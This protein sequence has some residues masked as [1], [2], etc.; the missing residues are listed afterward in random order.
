MYVACI[1]FSIVCSEWA[2]EACMLIVKKLLRCCSNGLH[3]YF[4]QMFINHWMI[5]QKSLNGNITINQWQH[6]DSMHTSPFPLDQEYNRN[7]REWLENSKAICVC[8]NY[9]ECLKASPGSTASLWIVTGYGN[10]RG[11]I[12]TLSWACLCVTLDSWKFKTNS[13]RCLFWTGL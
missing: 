5:G 7:S 1:V 3:N 2:L 8:G 6:F 13:N 12:Y 4:F 10:V 11:H 9:G